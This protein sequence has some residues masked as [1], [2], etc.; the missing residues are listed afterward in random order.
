MN[1][2]TQPTPSVLTELGIYPSEVIFIQPRRQRTHYRAV[3]NWLTRDTPTLK[4][5]NLKRI[6][7]HLQALDHLCEVEDWERVNIV[8]HSPVKN[9][10]IE[11]DYELHRQLEVWGYYG[12][13]IK[14]YKKIL[15][16]KGIPHSLQLLS[17]IGL[18]NSY[19]RLANYSE[20]ISFSK[21]ALVKSREINDC[22][23]EAT[24][25]ANLGI[26]C[27]GLGKIKDAISYFQESL[28]VAQEAELIPEKAM[29]L[30]N[31]GNIYGLQRQFTK[32]ISYL[33]E[34]RE[35]AHHIGDRILESKALANLGNANAYLKNYDKAAK[36]FEQYLEISRELEN[37]SGETIAL[38]C[39][40]ELNR[41]NKQYQKALDCLSQ[42]LSIAKET[43]EAASEGI[44]LGNIGSVHGN[45]GNYKKAIEYHREAL[46]ITQKIGDRQ[47]A[48]LARLNLRL[49][50]L[51]LWFS[52]VWRRNNQQGG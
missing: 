43:Q 16:N 11:T 12:E 1:Q 52:Q 22:Q 19:S 46:R 35:I 42:S 50:Q 9:R 18:G 34:S 51:V 6:D 20:S 38:N 47:G 36:Y 25:L 28:Q 13:Q 17:L 31:L 10:V 32:A 48:R 39:L 30:G 44:A 3:V 5:S 14:I 23:G 21:T 37:R 7:T 15:G 33:E 29:A 24:A 40:G 2:V 41:R 45:M 49:T 8:L 26:G 4:N 27:V